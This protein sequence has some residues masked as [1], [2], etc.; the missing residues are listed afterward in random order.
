MEDADLRV[1]TQPV[2][3]TLVLRDGRRETVMFYLSIGARAHGGTETISDFLNE[4]RPFIPVRLATGDSALFNREA[5]LYVSAAKDAAGLDRLVG[6]PD[7]DLV[8]VELDTGD[9]LEGVLVHANPSLRARLS[10]HFNHH[11]LFF[12]LEMGDAVL[13]V[14]K[15]RVLT[16]LL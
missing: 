7:V 13:F 5:V 4:P 1:P 14:N 12:T 15:R 10:D 8:R 16:I 3:V 9:E 6:I 2:E 11:E